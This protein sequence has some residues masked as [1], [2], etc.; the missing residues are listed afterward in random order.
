MKKGMGWP[1][2]VVTILAS[3][4][5]A[6]VIVMRIANDDPS[7]AVE[8]DYYRKAVH[9]DSTMAQERE[10]ISLGWGIETRIDS[11]GDGRHTRVA[12]RLRDA[13]SYPLPGARVAVMARF[14]ARAND[15]LTALLTEESPGTYVTTLPI[16]RPG[17]WDVRVDATHGS[18]RFSASSRVSA[19]RATV[20]MRTAP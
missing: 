13:S 14:N 10:N 6:N 11:I 1:I 8:P 20:A 3:T 18:Q 2:G 12:I 19:V 15:T 17:E 16:A 7:F 4:V 5:V 9:F